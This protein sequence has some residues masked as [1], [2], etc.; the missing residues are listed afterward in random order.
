MNKIFNI[1]NNATNQIEEFVPIKPGEVSM[2]VCGPT[3]YNYAH[4]GNARPIVVF[5]T[6]RRV[7]QADGYKVEYISNVTDVD[8]KIINKAIEEGVDE[9]VIAT[10]YLNAY[11]DLRKK[12]NTV[13][14]AATPKV[15]ETMDEIIAFI[16][17][18][19]AKGYAYEVSG[20]VYFR[21]SK[22]KDYGLHSKQNI[23]ELEVGSRVQENTLKE[24][25]LDFALWKKTDKGINWD[26]PFGSGRPGWHTECVVMIN[27]HFNSKIDIHGGGMDL[28]FPH[29][30]NEIAQAKACFNHGLA[31]YWMYNGML[32]IDG[33][34]MSKSLGNVL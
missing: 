19:M 12:L 29:H 34:K 11:L 9:E 17:E 24:N 31:N 2:Y 6:L 14:L 20:D 5:D 21:V 25:P 28:K 8:D 27:D 26:S 1:Y 10:R 4:I 18:L 30:E 3:V 23:E 15:T 33:E 7:L 32:N 13:E 22:I 16:S